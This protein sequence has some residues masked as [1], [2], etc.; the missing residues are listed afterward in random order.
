MNWK[1]KLTYLIIYS[2]LAS[3]LL[4]GCRGNEIQLTEDSIDESGVSLQVGTRM[5]RE[6]DGMVQIFVPSSTFLMGAGESD[7]MAG[8]GETPAHLVSLDSFWI[9]E[10]EV[11]NRQYA[12]CVDNEI[13]APPNIID[14][15]IYN[16]EDYPVVGVDWLD[17]QDYCNWVGGNLPTEAEWEY[18][19]KGIEGLIYPWGNEYDGNHLN[20]CDVNCIES[21]SEPGIDD[22][23]RNSAPVGTFPAGASWVGVLDMAGNVWEWVE[24]WCGE[25]DDGFQDNPTGPED[26]RC[27]II[28]G[29]AWAS[30]PAG[31]RTTYRI[32]NTSEISPDIRH[33]NIGFRC[34]I[35]ELREENH[36]Y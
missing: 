32:I 24:D 2:L 4:L 11:S 35:P 19:A 17:A 26:G 7:P 21:W 33:P 20:G 6:Q 12:I 3:M 8:E 34:V 9:D 16:G 36:E 5:T 22:G 15:D 13:C 1:I 30:P 10:T 23:Y 18:A 27:K 25:Y 31:L 28:R 29:G 14:N